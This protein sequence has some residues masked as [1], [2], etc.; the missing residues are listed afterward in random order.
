MKTMSPTVRFFTPEICVSDAQKYL[1][2]ILEKRGVDIVFLP[3]A[4]EALLQ[5][6]T[7]LDAE[8]YAVHQDMAEKRMRHRDIEDWPIVACALLLDC[9]IWTEDADFFGSAI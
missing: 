2:T 4:I 6:I 7:I 3:K 1:P 8:I 9:P 5:N